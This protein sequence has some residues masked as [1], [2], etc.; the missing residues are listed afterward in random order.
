[1]K[2]GKVCAQMRGTPIGRVVL[3]LGL[4]LMSNTGCPETNPCDGNPCDDDNLCTTDTCTPDANAAAGRVCTNEAVD[5]GGKVCNP[6]DGSCVDCLDDTS[7]DDANPCTDGTCSETG[8]CEYINNA[9]DCDDGDACTEDDVCADGVCSG[10]PL[11]CPEGQECKAESGLCRAIDPCTSDSECDNGEFCD[12]AETCATDG[13]CKGGA[14]PCSADQ[15]CDDADNRCVECLDD[16]H[17]PQGSRCADGDCRL[18]GATRT[19]PPCYTPGE[20]FAVEVDLVPAEDTL[21]VGLQDFPPKGWT[22]SDISHGGVW[23]ATNG[24]V[25]W[26]FPK[27]L[28]GPVQPATLT[29]SVQP[30]A[31]ATGEARFTGE[32]NPN[33]GASGP[34]QGETRIPACSPD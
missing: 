4:L 26:F 31:T 12:G 6:T 21:V 7:C 33:G 27:D 9:A 18:V 8:T 29:Y 13:L 32:V 17:C 16:S 11:V 14:T 3:G 15:I 10:I 28:T 19:L 2:H 34:T 25:K 30:P 1:M 22:V 24:A 5:C 23:D 20:P